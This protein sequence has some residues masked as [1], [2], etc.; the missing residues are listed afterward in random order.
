MELQASSKEV[1]DW[2]RSFAEGRLLQGDAREFYGEQ[3]MGLDC[4]PFPASCDFARQNRLGSRLKCGTP[5][6]R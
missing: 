3:Q 1:L 4:E 2:G 6:R 5:R